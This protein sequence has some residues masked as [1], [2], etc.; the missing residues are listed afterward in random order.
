VVEES[1]RG[2]Y[3]LIGTVLLAAGITPLST[4]LGHKPYWNIQTYAGIAL[5]ALGLLVIV[6]ALT[7]KGRPGLRQGPPPPAGMVEHS[8]TSAVDTPLVSNFGFVPT[9]SFVGRVMELEW[10]ANQFQDYDGIRVVALSGLGGIGKSRIAREYATRRGAYYRVTWRIL[11]STEADIA[12]AVS[13]LHVAL[14]GSE[15]APTLE[16][17]SYALDTLRRSLEEHEPWLLIVDS[18]ADVR[19]LLDILPAE[20]SGHILLTTRNATIGVQ[21]LEVGPL[22]TD[23]AVQ[24]LK[25]KLGVI[26]DSGQAT[27]LCELL[28]GLPLALDQAASYIAAAQITIGDYIALF[29]SRKSELLKLNHPVDYPETVATTWSLALERLVRNASAAESLLRLLSTLPDSD[30]PRAILNH[31]PT[32]GPDES[33]T[34]RDAVAAN[35]AVRQLREF[36][37]ISADTDV[38]AVHAL[39]ASV[40]TDSMTPELRGQYWSLATRGIAATLVAGSVDLG[41]LIALMVPIVSEEPRPDAIAEWLLLVTMVGKALV[42]TAPAAGLEIAARGLALIGQSPGADPRAEAVLATTAGDLLVALGRYGEAGPLFG[43]ALERMHRDDPQFLHVFIMYAQNLR[44]VG[45]EGA[46]RGVKMLASE[47]RD[48]RRDGGTELQIAALLKALGVLQ[49]VPLN[50]LAVARSHLSEALEIRERLL[51]ARGRLDNRDRLRSRV[52]PAGHW[53][54]ARGTR[55]A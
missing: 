26:D 7:G 8:A 11:A 54:K 48:R 38:L 31:L 27:R 6:A 23:D 34:L 9:T 5:V 53:Q 49:H 39:V 33:A 17:P 30:V 29:Q 47:L 4:S 2:I 37:I 41:S 40:V 46:E 52:S 14:R 13:E 1:R 28:G 19:L 45:R 20:S 50:R 21:S 10:V 43:Q 18:I 55:T 16:A 12:A 32:D 3:G 51:G 24:L 22:P 42:Y 44:Q 36:S 25:S 15:D 35:E